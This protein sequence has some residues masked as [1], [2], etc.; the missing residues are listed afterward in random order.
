[1]RDIAVAF[2][3]AGR[4]SFPF[5]YPSPFPK[6]PARGFLF[7]DYVS[8]MGLSRAG[9]TLERGNGNGSGRG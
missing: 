9:P 6:K 1:M 7:S 4:T 5:P 8:L 3:R 2:S